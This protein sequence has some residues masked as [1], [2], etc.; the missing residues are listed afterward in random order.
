MELSRIEQQRSVLLQVLLLLVMISLGVVTYISYQKGDHLIIP[1]LT[2]F[3]LIACLFV[4]AKE[5]LLKKLHADLIEEIIR[6]EREVKT[7]NQEVKG[8]KVQLQE[9]KEKADQIGL[10]LKEITSLYRAISTVNSVQD[11]QRTFDTVLRAALDL[12][13]ND[14]GSLMLLD[15]KTEHLVIVSAQGL[16]QQMLRDHSQRIGEG[17]AGWVAKNCEP[18]LITE[19]SK[20][21]E[22]L[23][24]L[25]NPEVTVQSAMS[26]PL[27]VRNR[28]IGVMN[29]R[30]SP[31]GEKKAFTEHDLRIVSIFTQHASVSIE[32][33][34]L[35]N[36]VQRL[37]KTPLPA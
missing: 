37:K 29:F 26:V 32:N 4:I 16:N 30:I 24:G 25:L 33:I 31:D 20:Q 12:V 28:V 14:T 2:I 11:P 27:H 9:E 34:Q 15:E 36:T 8:G 5:R 10:R 7:L 22:R 6:K 19:E 13:E 3:S 18:I 35:V 17:I 1:S 23:K 21:D